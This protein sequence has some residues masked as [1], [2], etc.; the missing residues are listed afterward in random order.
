MSFHVNRLVVNRVEAV[1]E[2]L[3]AA[4]GYFQAALLIGPDLH[5]AAWK[6]GT[7]GLNVDA[8]RTSLVYD[9]ETRR[10]NS[11]DQI[12]GYNMNLDIRR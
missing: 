3:L 10:C 4:L 9:K 2:Y 8:S 11:S 7:K 6:A 5:E 1:T 12:R